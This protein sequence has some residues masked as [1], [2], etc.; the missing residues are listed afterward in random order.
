MLDLSTLFNWNTKQVFF[1]I[2]AKYP[3]HRRNDKPTEAV[4]WD[5]I[6]PATSAPWHH[7]QYIHP[8]TSR[9]PKSNG[10]AGEKPYRSS[11]NG[12]HAGYVQL[13]NQRPK[14]VISDPSGKLAGR[15][16]AELELRWNVQPWVGAL[17]WTNRKTVGRWQA[18]KGGKSEK[19]SFPDLTTKAKKDD[20]KTVKGGEGNRG[21]PA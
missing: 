5:A 10:K 1:Y 12:T 17:L 14:Y 6:V 8:A 18:F 16:N 3:S 2:V 11:A 9:T 15:E 13:K 4:V 20:L 7:N 21:K 19:F